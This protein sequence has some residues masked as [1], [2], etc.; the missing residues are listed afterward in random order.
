MLV[1]RHETKHYH[2]LLANVT[3][4]YCS[5]IT[6]TQHTHTH[7]VYF[8]SPILTV[9]LGHVLCSTNLHWRSA[10]LLARKEKKKLEENTI[11][12]DTNKEII[13]RSLRPLGKYCGRGLV[14]LWCI[15]KKKHCFAR[16]LHRQMALNMAIVNN[17]W[18]ACQC[19]YWYQLVSQSVYPSNVGFTH[20]LHW[21]VFT[22]D[23]DVNHRTRRSV[24]S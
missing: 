2:R 12:L 21:I 20:T 16:T 15:T 17:Q 18:C 1:K 5:S 24:Y 22:I 23:F 4:Y 7:T 10:G 6:S 11:H 8:C 13:S 14:S 19:H 3:A 9:M